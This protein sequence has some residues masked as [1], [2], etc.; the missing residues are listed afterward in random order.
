MQNNKLQDN[1]MQVYV[2]GMTK[3]SEIEKRHIKRIGSY[4]NYFHNLL[5]GH[6]NVRKNPDSLN[7]P[8]K[9]G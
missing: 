9:S 2:Y 6:D 7:H 3:I 1:T 5:P 8:E 4:L